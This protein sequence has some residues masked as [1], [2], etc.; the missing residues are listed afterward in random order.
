MRRKKTK[1]QDSKR[2]YVM[3][4]L[5]I[6]HN[7]KQKWRSDWLVHLIQLFELPEWYNG[8]KM[9]ASRLYFFAHWKQKLKLKDEV[10]IMKLL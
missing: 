2:I 5:T 7:V 8:I 9:K 1:K 4:N 3:G 10:F 6:H